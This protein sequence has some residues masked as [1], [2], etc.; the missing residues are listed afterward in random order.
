MWHNQEIM[1][2]WKDSVTT[3]E[4]FNDKVMR[5]VLSNI[6]LE[7]PE[8]KPTA[9]ELILD[10]LS[11][12]GFEH[13]P[14]V[15]GRL[16]F[17]HPSNGAFILKAGD[18]VYNNEDIEALCEAADNITDSDLKLDY[19]P[20]FGSSSIEINIPEWLNN[21]A[22]YMKLTG[23]KEGEIPMAV[24]EKEPHVINL[25]EVCVTGLGQDKAALAEPYVT[26]SCHSANVAEKVEAELR[27]NG[28][29]RTNLKV[30]H[31]TIDMLFLDKYNNTIT[32]KITDSIVVNF[33]LMAYNGDR[34]DINFNSFISGGDWY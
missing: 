12:L 15:I 25:D 3:K 33:Y 4:E 23:Y 6:K 30:S 13:Q 28:Y 14:N 34:Y 24:D 29:T 2:G 11:A 27:K 26:L 20:K 9:F 18:L 8:Y 31:N 22:I 16:Y 1:V 10:K 19:F 7:L 5:D 32:L 17:Y 21:G